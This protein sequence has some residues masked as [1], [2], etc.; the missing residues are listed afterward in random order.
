MAPAAAQSAAAIV[1]IAI[2]SAATVVVVIRDDR[3]ISVGVGREVS[4]GGSIYAGLLLV[5]V[6][7]GATFISRKT[8]TLGLHSVAS[9]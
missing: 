7:S 8:S 9:V 1:A 3:A 6:I 2:V 5:A 4:T